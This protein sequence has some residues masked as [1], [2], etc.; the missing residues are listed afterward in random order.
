[1]TVRTVAASV[2]GTPTSPMGY[3]G[4]EPTQLVPVNCDTTSFSLS[5]TSPLLVSF[6]IFGIV[7]QHGTRTLFVARTKGGKSK[8]LVEY[9]YYIFIFQHQ[10]YGCVAFVVDCCNKSKKLFRRVWSSNHHCIAGYGI[11]VD[12]TNELTTASTTVWSLSYR[13]QELSQV[14]LM[15]ESFRVP[16]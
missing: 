4:D 15:T 3:S 6:L 12:L 9:T 7:C 8:L 5:K 11:V 14:G 13:L 1:M 16:K 10:V 2:A